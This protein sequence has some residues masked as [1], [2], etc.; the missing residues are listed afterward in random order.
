MT[1][2]GAAWPATLA[3]VLAAAL[4]VVPLQE[5]RALGV[6][7][8]GPTA[9]GRATTL[10]A[11]PEPERPDVAAML[12][13]PLLAPTR[14]PVAGSAATPT[15]TGPAEAPPRLVGVM[16]S[17]PRRSAIVAMPGGRF[18]VVAQGQQV[19]VFLVQGI[20]SPDPTASPPRRTTTECTPA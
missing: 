6:A 12:A 9:P 8:S 13:R 7:P 5:L 2:W 16:L 4:A 11:L 10:P 3:G 17:G 14:R 18:A 1:V 15:A 20:V 19:G